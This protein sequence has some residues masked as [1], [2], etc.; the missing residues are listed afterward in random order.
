MSRCRFVFTVLTVIMILSINAGTVLAESEPAPDPDVLQ[1]GV[2]TIAPWPFYPVSAYVYSKTPT[3]IFLGNI[4]ATKYR[5]EV[6]DLYTGSRVYTY[7]GAGEIHGDYVWLKPDIPLKY[8]DISGTNG[9]YSWH[10][11]AKVGISWQGYTTSPYEFWVGT[12]GFYSPFDVDYRKWLTLRGTWSVVSPGYLKNTGTYQYFDSMVYKHIISDDFT[13]AASL[14][15]KD[16]NTGHYAGVIV[17]G[18]PGSLGPAGEW[19]WGFYVVYRDDG[20]AAVYARD[21][22]GNWETVFPWTLNPI[23]NPEGFNNIELV[24]GENRTKL[25]VLFNDS[26]WTTITIPGGLRDGY[27]GI[28]NYRNGALKEAVKVDWAE[29]TVQYD[30]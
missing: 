9:H 4:S 18:E 27:V 21:G 14:K 15:I 19:Q 5:I 25:Y 26:L 24:T 17:G 11:E 3:F 2:D 30:V 29:L 7:K 22:A 28:V 13:F 8:Y 1:T 12:P 16:L 10:V 6:F 23:I 20:F